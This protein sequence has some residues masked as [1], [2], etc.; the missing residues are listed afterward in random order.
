MGGTGSSSSN[1][2]I[3]LGLS[4]VP[5]TETFLFVM[6]LM[7]YLTTILGDM[8]IIILA[9]MDSKLHNPMYF[10][11]THFSFV[12]ICLSSVIV[13][14]LLINLSSRRQT[15]STPGCLTQ[16]YFF[17]LTANME[18]FLLAVM[19]YD[20]Y[21]AICKPLHYTLVMRKKV[22]G[23]LVAVSWMITALHALLYTVM[24]SLLS[25][26]SSN[27]I[28]HFF[29][30]VPPLLKL[31]CSDTSGYQLVT[32]TEA[33]AIILG[34]F[35]SIIASYTGI[36]STVVKIKSMDGRH[37]AF[38][39]CSSHLI[40]VALFYASV[41]FMYFR[42]PLNYTVDY[43]MVVSVIYTVIIPMLNPFIYALRNRD[44]KSAWKRV[45]CLSDTCIIS[46]HKT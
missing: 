21:V 34:P 30:D 14:Q 39:T 6:F 37:K 28:H 24:T 33:V 8:Y 17:L 22:C 43:D 31:S 29:C 3:L 9:A 42:P 12:D 20:R 18:F 27:Q 11:L 38:S 40:L 25:F 45:R 16:L 32:Y 36:I 35:L 1:E 15:I 23:L 26:C 7:F 13:P 10:F 41:F 44:M 2:F 4:N 5:E 46:Q 19:G